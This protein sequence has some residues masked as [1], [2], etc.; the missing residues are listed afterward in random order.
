MHELSTTSVVGWDTL[1]GYYYPLSVDIACP[2]CGRLANFRSRDPHH[3]TSRHTIS[4]TADCTACK[5]A[6]FLGVMNPSQS[7][8]TQCGLLVMHPSPNLQHQVVEGFDLLPGPIQRA[9]R[10]TVTVYN[11]GVYS[12]TATLCRRTLEG[13]VNELQQGEED[14]PLFTR[15]EKLNE[16]VNL[17]QPLITL[18]HAVRKAGNLGAHFDLR[19]EPDKQTVQAM[20][21]LIEYMLEYVYTLPGM[22]EKL[23]QHVEALGQEEA[24]QEQQAVD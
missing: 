7:S 11:T 9:Y 23:N 22:I 16:S 15:L 17:A 5:Q 4:V 6:I 24:A 10:D 12:A 1:S 14:K 2:Y 3:D 18:S 21:E 13:I 19:K 8:P 20:L